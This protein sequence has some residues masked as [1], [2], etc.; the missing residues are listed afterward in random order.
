MP[1]G[2]ASA[3]KTLGFELP[4]AAQEV[5][6]LPTDN[7]SR[8][9]FAFLLEGFHTGDHLRS[10]QFYAVVRPILFRMAKKRRCGLSLDQVEDVVQETFLALLRR[11][12]V[13]F[14]PDRGDV[15]EYLLGRLLNAIK[16]IRTQYGSTRGF[17]VPLEELKYP[18]LSR[19]TVEALD[20]RHLACRILE[21]VPNP[22]REACFR[23]L[24]EDEAQTV[25]ALEMGLTRFA[26]ARKLRAIK[27]AALQM[28]A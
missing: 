20:S 24:A 10:E 27:L 13:R 25:V 23:V 17:S 3:F 15:S 22:I 11:G 9:E 19:D 5:H 2:A 6:E 12:V 4:F 1:T 21:G 16:A 14:D 8:F 7:I 26:L 28:A 18:L